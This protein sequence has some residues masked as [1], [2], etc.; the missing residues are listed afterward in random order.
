[1]APGGSERE[2][3]RVGS[4]PDQQTKQHPGKR[5][6]NKTRIIRT[7]VSPMNCSAWRTEAHFASW[8][9]LC[10]DDRIRGDKVL[11]RGTRQGGH[12]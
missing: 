3:L 4:V 8:L 1:M 11:A 12:C 7:S 2:A 5:R 6:A 9:G 10:P